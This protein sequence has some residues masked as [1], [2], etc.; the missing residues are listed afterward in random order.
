MAFFQNTSEGIFISVDFR[1]GFKER[2]SN[3]LQE[4]RA[5]IFWDIEFHEGGDIA[6]D[7]GGDVN[8]LT[9]SGDNGIL[10]LEQTVIEEV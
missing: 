2:L 5:D 4:K 9:F 3:W 7:F 1:N 6:L 8:T 10:V